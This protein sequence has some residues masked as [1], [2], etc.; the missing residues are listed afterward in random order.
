MPSKSHLAASSSLHHAPRQ[1]QRPGRG[2]DEYRRTIY[3]DAASHSPLPILSRMSLSAVAASGT[4]SRDSARHIS[5]TPSSLDSAYSCVNASMPPRKGACA[6]M[7]FTNSR[8]SAWVAAFSDA[9]NRA[10]ASSFAL[11]LPRPPETTQKY[12]AEDC[13]K[14][15]G[16]CYRRVLDLSPASPAHAMIPRHRDQYFSVARARRGLARGWHA[17]RAGAHHGR[18]A[19]RPSVACTPDRKDHTAKWWSVFS[20][21]PRSSRRTKIST[22]IPA[23]SKA[24]VPNSQEPNKPRLCA[25]CGRNLS[26]WFCDQDRGRR[27]Q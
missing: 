9:E 25:V 4:R 26:R 8:A 15:W 2:V 1:H 6:R 16:L 5:T 14:P 22:A 11:S 10:R 12:R 18:A 3:P 23:I 19:R 20:S 21:T 7:R 27:P 13:Q 17:H 24:I